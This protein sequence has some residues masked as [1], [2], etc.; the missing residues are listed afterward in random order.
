MEP[1][2]SKF[3]FQQPKLH[4]TIADD[5]QLDLVKFTATKGLFVSGAVTPALAGVAVTLRSE[6]LTEPATAVTDEEGRYSLGPF[7]RDI[8]YTVAAEKLGYVITETERGSFS[9][10]KLASVVVSVV[11]W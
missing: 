11:T 2:A 8:Q 3:L 5:C 7:S 9:A 4:V 6:Q 10:K 1:I